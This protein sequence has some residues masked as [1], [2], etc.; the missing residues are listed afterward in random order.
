MWITGLTAGVVACG[1][2]ERQAEPPQNA[3]TAAAAASAAVP[4]GAVVEVRMTGNGR[5][6][7][8]FEPNA[9]TITPGMTVRFINVSGGPHNV[10]FW[11]DSIPAGARDGLNAAMPRRLTD[12]HG[13]YA[14]QPNETYDIV[15]GAEALRGAYKGYCAPH[16]ALGMTLVIT[17]Q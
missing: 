13:P 15:F 12:L 17:V 6:R 4:P 1:G 16:L 9:L 2:G 3:Q 8:A 11:A 5:D 7:A 10:A 14:V